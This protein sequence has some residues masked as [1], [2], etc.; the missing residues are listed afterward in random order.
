M[1][2]PNVPPTWRSAMIRAEPTPLRSAESAPRA[3]F[4]APGRAKPRPAPMMVTHS[5]A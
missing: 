4:I 2:T 5:A 3:A 1:A